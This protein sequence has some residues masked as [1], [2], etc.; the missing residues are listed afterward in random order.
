MELQRNG[1]E[2]TRY[3]L[4]Y[5][6]GS[7]TSNLPR[8]AR[9]AERVRQWKLSPNRDGFSLL[10]KVLRKK[11]YEMLRFLGAQYEGDLCER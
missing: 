2:L 4:S 11:C 9:R 6:D 7:Q 1:D 5:G 10:R 3:P 8:S